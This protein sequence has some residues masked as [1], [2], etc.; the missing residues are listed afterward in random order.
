MFQKEKEILWAHHFK[1]GI[2]PETS[3]LEAPRNCKLTLESHIESHLSKHRS[4]VHY[5]VGPGTLGM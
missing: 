2:L 3:Q 4:W 1:T 5:F